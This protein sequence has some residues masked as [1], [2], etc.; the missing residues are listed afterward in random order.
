MINGYSYVEL[1]HISSL[2]EDETIYNVLIGLERD[3]PRQKFRLPH[4]GYRHPVRRYLRRK[5]FFCACLF[6][7]SISPSFVEAFDGQLQ[8]HTAILAS[9]WPHIASVEPHIASV[10]P[11]F[12]IDQVWTRFEQVKSRH[13]LF[14]SSCLSIALSLRLLS[15]SFLY[16]NNYCLDSMQQALDPTP[17]SSF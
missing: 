8:P 14:F 4:C 6:S 12:F 15:S 1:L 11:R 5:N 3:L 10:E 17:R 9:L 7:I 2:C 16:L 13:K